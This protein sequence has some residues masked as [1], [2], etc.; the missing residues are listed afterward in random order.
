[1]ST[2]VLNAEVK[3]QDLATPK[4]D[5]LLRQT[6]RPKGMLTVVGRRV[7]NVLRDYF[8]QRNEEGNKQ[9]WPRSN[10][11][12]QT[13]AAAT[14][15]EGA[16]DTEATVRIA[17]REFLHKLEGGTIRAKNG[18]MLTIPLT[19]EAKKKGSP[20][21][22]NDKKDLFVLKS[23]KENRAYL[24]RKKGKKDLELLYLLIASV[25]QEKDPRAL[26]PKGTL[27]AAAEDEAGK[28]LERSLA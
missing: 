25:H 12:S 9:G 1:M 26:P 28:F 4:L 15:F 24:A 7:E 8:L 10:F 18:R 27:E 13:V 20:S 2:E 17:S 11:W 3:I 21:E 23:K 22:W 19:E 14:R 6:K 16:T 5:A